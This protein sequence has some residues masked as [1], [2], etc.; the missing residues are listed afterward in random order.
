MEATENH[1]LEE[2]V[3]TLLNGWSRDPGNVKEVFRELKET[4]SRKPG[5]E[6]N[7]KPRPGVSYSL[8]GNVRTSLE[9][10]PT[11]FVLID[12]IDDDPDNRWLSVCL[13]EEKITD[14]EQ[15]GEL[16][17][18]GILGE[19]GYC[20]DVFEYSESDLIYLRQ[21]IDEAYLHTA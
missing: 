13:Y 11:L 9:K 1:V 14:P 6:L 5:V 10:K 4:I 12:V 16:V 7:F 8:R 21:R 2:A 15:A 17:P 3:S 19:D 20:F 18:A